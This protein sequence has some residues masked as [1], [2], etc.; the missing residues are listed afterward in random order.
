MILLNSDLTMK[1]NQGE[2]DICLT[3]SE[4]YIKDC[5]MTIQFEFLQK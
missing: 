3:C 5:E 4:F 2:K 1:F